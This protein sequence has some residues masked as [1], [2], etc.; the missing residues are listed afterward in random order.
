MF[1]FFSFSFLFLVG[2]FRGSNPALCVLLLPVWAGSISLA[3]R[4]QKKWG[5]SLDGWS[6][7]SVVIEF[8]SI[9][10]ERHQTQN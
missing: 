6:I 4:S 7:E 8:V 1:I 9:Q 5:G 10:Q 2:T 3:R